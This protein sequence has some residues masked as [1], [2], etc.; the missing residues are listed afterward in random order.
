MD[1]RKEGRREKGRIPDNA[2]LLN[3]NSDIDL[4]TPVVCQ[5]R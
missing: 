1:G 3:N 2:K 5:Q 4:D